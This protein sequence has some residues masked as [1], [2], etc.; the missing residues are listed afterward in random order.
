GIRLR[1]CGSTNGMFVNG[2]RIFEALVTGPITLRIGDTTLGII[3]LDETVPRQRAPTDRFGDR[4]GR[5]A[6][7]PELFPDLERVAPTDH[8][9]LIEGETGTGKDIVAE[10]IHRASSRADRPYVIF[11]CGAV[12]PSLAESELF[13]HERGAFTG[14]VGSRPGVF[15]QANGGT[16]FLDE[17]G[18]LP[19]DL[20]PK[21]LRALENRHARR[22]SR[23]PPTTPPC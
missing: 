14:A 22:L 3:P 12:T 7:L 10:S 20:Q 21:L 5:S 15:E 4:L 11:D 13:G 1:D 2:M 9:V 17:I 8:T 6:R 16:L 23:D 18:E 19:K